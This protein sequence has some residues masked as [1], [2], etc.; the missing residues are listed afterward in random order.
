[1]DDMLSDCWDSLIAPQDAPH[2]RWQHWV[3]LVEYY[4]TK[5]LTYDTDKLAAISGI[6]NGLQKVT[7]DEYLA[8]LWK[9]DLRHQLLWHVKDPEHSNRIQP[10]TA[11]TWP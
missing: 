4:S 11:P 2:R 5:K 9:E 10:Y 3:Y 8:G 7:G 6:A 1:M